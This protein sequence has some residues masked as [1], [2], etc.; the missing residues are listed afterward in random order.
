MYVI[1]GKYFKK[2]N[3]NNGTYRDPKKTPKGLTKST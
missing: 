1:S 2:K 3:N